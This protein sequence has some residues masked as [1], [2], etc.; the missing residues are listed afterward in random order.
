MKVSLDD[1]YQGALLRLVVG[2][3]LGTTLEFSRPGTFTPITDTESFSKGALLAVNLGNDVDTVGAVYGQ[4]TGAY[5]G[6]N[7][8]PTRWLEKLYMKWEISNLANSLYQLSNTQIS[9]EKQD[10]TDQ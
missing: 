10:Q 3:A 1:R 5:Y 6:L 8:I 7:G 9:H 2:D 4:I